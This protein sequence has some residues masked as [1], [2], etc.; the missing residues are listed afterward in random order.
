MI[1]F[2]IFSIATIGATQ[3]IVFG[4]IFEKVR[5]GNSFL[6][7]PQC[8]GFWIGVFFASLSNLTTLFSYN[9][10]LFDIFIMGC[11]SSVLSYIVYVAFGDYGINIRR[12]SD[13]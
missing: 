2:L 10:S 9:G 8:V 12:K 5:D 7:C 1:S 13:E 6:V 11:I 3:I 4:K